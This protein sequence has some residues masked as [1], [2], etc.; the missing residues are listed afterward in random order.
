MAD[1]KQ[2]APVPPLEALGKLPREPGNTPDRL[3]RLEQQLGM[4]QQRVQH[5]E[6]ENA[7]LKQTVREESMRILGMAF[8]SIGEQMIIGATAGHKFQAVECDDKHPINDETFY[9]RRVS[10]TELRVHVLRKDV[11]SGKEITV[12]VEVPKLPAG[13]AKAITEFLAKVPADV[14]SLAFNVYREA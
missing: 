6:D 10:D 2:Q 14:P 11:Q 8:A 3:F 7:H 9:V 5:L 13:M 1:E 4:V 12:D